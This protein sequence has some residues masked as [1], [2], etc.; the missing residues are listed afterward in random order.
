MNKISRRQL[1][2]RLLAG[3]S[4]LTLEQFIAACTPK[5]TSSPTSAPATSLSTSK[6]Q[7]SASSTPIPTNPPQATT[8]ASTSAPSATNPPAPT[9]SPTPANYDMV[10]VRNAE[11][12]ALVRKAFE[13]FGGI[14][15]FIKP[16]M[17]VIIKPNICVAYH[18]Y[19]YAATTNPWVVGTL[20]KMC[21]E[22]GAGSVRVMDQPFGGTAKDAYAISGIQDQVKANGGEMVIMSGYR[23]VPAV[24][25]DAKAMKN[26]VLYDEFLKADAIINVPIAKDH[27]LSRL[28]LGMKNLMGIVDDREGMHYNLGQK[29]ADLLTLVK[30]QLTLV[31]AVRILTANGP[32]GGNLDDVKKLD[33]VI[34]TQDVV[35][36]DTY[37]ATLFDVTPMELANIGAAVAMKLGRSDLKNLKIQ[38]INLA[39]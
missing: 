1:L 9:L 30:P 11:P 28:T 33:T 21:F 20:V 13:V 6:P 34:L 37:A 3:A 8:S 7:A 15:K 23:Y 2:L 35:A 24:I 25:K 17:K 4:A 12:E 27:S 14:N 10:V 18:T 38:E 5:P 22:A 26:V 19:E 39:A 31:D 16:G 36:A 29:L 32:T